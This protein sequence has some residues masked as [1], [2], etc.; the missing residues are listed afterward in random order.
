MLQIN[1]VNV[2]ET[3][4]YLQILFLLCKFVTHE[5]KECFVSTNALLVEKSVHATI[6]KGI[7]GGSEFTVLQ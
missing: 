7:V 2:Q 6:P 5:A 1:L 4:P 3:S